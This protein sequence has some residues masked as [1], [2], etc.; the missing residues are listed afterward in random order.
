MDSSLLMAAGASFV[1]GLLGYII[2]RLWIKPIVGYTST[3]RRLD[4]ALTHCLA[5]MDESAGPEKQ[6]ARQ[7][8]HGA[9][10]T[11]RKHAIALVASYGADIPYWYRL[12]LDSR[13]ESPAEASGLLT[14]LSKIRDQEQVKNR[15]DAVRKIMGLK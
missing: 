9:L 6:G 7:C 12:L 11:A 2:A 13:K 4:Q 10:R 5:L 1:V 15:I 8:R 3:K 14:N